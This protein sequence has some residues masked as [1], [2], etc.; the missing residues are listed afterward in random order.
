LET[1]AGLAGLVKALL[2][3]KHRQVP[4]NLH[5]ETPNP[6][7]D[8]EGLKLRVNSTLEP[9]PETDGACIAGVNSFGFGGANAHVILESPEPRSLPRRREKPQAP[10]PV[11][12]SGRSGAALKAA[13][14][15]LARF[16]R[17]RGDAAL[18]DIAWS[19]AFR[20]E[21]HDHRAVVFAGDRDELALALDR[22][23]GDAAGASGVES[24][25][26]LPVAAECAFVYAGNGSQWEGMGRRLLSEDKFADAEIY[27][28]DDALV[29]R[30]EM[31]V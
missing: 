6:N 24:G 20:R 22:F 5:F 8:F 31:S 26:A 25:I 16:T 9:F 28:F 3:L 2:V 4:A 27:R 21:W 30:S 14:R 19:T 29:L 11:V 15:D 13:A 18:Y 1:A 7:I 23:A 12:V 17:E 10:V